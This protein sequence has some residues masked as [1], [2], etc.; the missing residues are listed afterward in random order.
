MVWL[1]ISLIVIFCVRDIVKHVKSGSC[2]GCAS[3]EN[4]CKG[5]CKSCSH[6]GDAGKEKEWNFLEKQEK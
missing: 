4:H 3:H 5:A 6:T 1:F 2:G